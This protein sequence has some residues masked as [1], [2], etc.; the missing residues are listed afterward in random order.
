MKAGANVVCQITDVFIGVLSLW[1]PQQEI[2]LGSH[3]GGKNN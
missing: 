2:K 1:L 3:W